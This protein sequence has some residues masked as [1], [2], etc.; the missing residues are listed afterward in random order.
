MPKQI[1]KEE[2]KEL[3]GEI[4][5]QIKE[6]KIWTD[7]DSEAYMMIN[8]MVGSSAL[9]C[10]MGSTTSK[11]LWDALQTEYETKGPRILLAD[12][13]IMSSSKISD[14]KTLG[15]YVKAVIEAASRLD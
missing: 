12:F 3:L 6:N 13:K 2:A 14:F 11:Q 8:S 10:V 7:E 5:V 4:E 15:E 1:S 9:Q